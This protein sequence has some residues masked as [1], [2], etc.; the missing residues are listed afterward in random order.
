[1]HHSHGNDIHDSHEDAFDEMVRERPKSGMMFDSV[2][3]IHEA[4]NSFAKVQGFS[5][6]CRSI[7]ITSKYTVISC[8]R[9]RNL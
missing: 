3:K 2:D 7:S 8:D 4:C 1:M 6:F 9:A 5:V